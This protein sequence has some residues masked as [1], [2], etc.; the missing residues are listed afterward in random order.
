M[1]SDQEP[2]PKAPSSQDGRGAPVQP[3]AADPEV[4]KRRP[5]L[6]RPPA[7][8]ALFVGFIF[9]M[10]SLRPTLLPHPPLSQ[11]V[12]GGLSLLI[13][14][15]LGGLVIG[16]ALVFNRRLGWS[17]V[18]AQVRQVARWVFLVVAIVAVVGGSL[19]WMAWQNDQRTMVTM[20]HISWTEI[21]VMLLVTA[22]VVVIFGALA[23]AIGTG[24]GWFDR[25]LGRHMPRALAHTAVAL[26]VAFVAVGLGNKLVVDAFL[27]RTSAAFEA[28][29]ST[30]EAGAYQPTSPDISG[31]PG[32]LVAW[33]TLGLQGRNW[34]SRTSTP[35]QIQAFVGPNV[36]V[37]QPIRAY[38]GLA[39]ASDV[40]QRAK[41]AVED[42]TRAG[43]FQRKVLVV[44]TA[45][46]SGWINPLTS[47][48]FEYEWA[49]NTAMVSMQYSYLPSWIAFLTDR[50]TAAE[51]GTAL[52]R[53]VYAKWST[54]P[55]D[56]RP[57]LIL[58][59]ESL[60][61]LGS[62][63]T[64]KASTASASVDAVNAHADG[65]LWVGPTTTNP[66]WGQVTAARNQGSP[67]WRPTYGDSS[68]V[69]FANTNEELPAA[70]SGR[71]RI[72]YLQ[73]PSDPVTWWSTS[74]I[75]SPPAWITEHP[76]G[77]DIPSNV[78]WFPIV[79]WLQTTGDLMEGFSTPA[80]HGHNYNN[81]WAQAV[82][83]VATP[84]GWTSADTDRL[85]AAMISLHGLG[86]N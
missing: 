8:G 71:P 35:A 85:A 31:G 65:V 77:S 6:W 7:L 74:T 82:T 27:G 29:D 14:Y 84:P 70:A 57:K 28:G 52:N 18:S 80:G 41:L 69:V 76:H 22:L 55:P 46:G 3:E 42:L 32:S 81:A 73:H 21:P 20:P 17:G 12:V 48:A 39:S 11:G 1:E 54:L 40:N 86:A 58:F 9:W 43:G 5:V 60:G 4:P 47:S 66:I 79:T 34:V 78:S 63:D 83:S 53:A 38:A 26:V 19:V 15:G 75:Y 56:A 67:V 37:M 23:R 16:A 13:G 59:G 64:Y 36:P 25:L 61:S 49:G 24:V 10:E 50:D 2:N 62:E 33:G 44:A 30:T 51:A 45:T 68:Q 72:V